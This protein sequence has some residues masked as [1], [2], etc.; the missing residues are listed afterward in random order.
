[1]AP[2]DF[3][4]LIIDRFDHTLAPDAVVGPGPT[5]DSV[6][7]LGEV[8]APARVGI[9]DEQAVLSVKTWGTIVGHPA[10]VRSDQASVGG[11]FLCGIW[12]RTSFL[13]DSERPI[14]W[15]VGSC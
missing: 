10:F 14:H 8:Y 4:G 13:V 2:P 5:V 1:M 11:R 6:R 3:A 15:T 7:G 12:N 9:H